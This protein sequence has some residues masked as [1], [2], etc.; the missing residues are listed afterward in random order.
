MKKKLSITLSI[1]TIIIIV[2]SFSWATII[3]LERDKEREESIVIPINKYF[4]H[5]DLK[6][7]ATKSE[8]TDSL[9]IS[10]NTYYPS[11]D[12]SFLIVH[13]T[14]KSKLFQTD[15]FD[16]SPFNNNCIGDDCKDVN[17]P[18]GKSPLF[19]IWKK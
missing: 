12:K 13:L 6:I 15:S 17:C 18:N 1:L 4:S 8:L 11:E 19:Y 16:F 9:T 10:D 2:L 7:K 3:Y 14:V 5:N